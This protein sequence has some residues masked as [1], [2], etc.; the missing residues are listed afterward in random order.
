MRVVVAPDEF[1]GTL[2]AVEA[3][4]AIAAGWAAA[5]PADRV[6]AVPLSDGGPGFVDVLAAALPGARTIAVQ[7]ED[8]LARPVEAR[9]LL[10]GTTAYVEAAQACGLHLLARAERDPKATTTYGVGQLVVAARDAG[11]TRI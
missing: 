9:F 6:D 8:P 3:A 2:S 11:A 7:V 4:R 1:G 5:A 10:D